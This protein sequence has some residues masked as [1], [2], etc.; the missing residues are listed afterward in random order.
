[1]SCQLNTANVQTHK[2]LSLEPNTE[3]CL[4]Y[5]SELHYIGTTRYADYIP[6]S[7][8]E[9]VVYQSTPDGN[10]IYNAVSLNFYGNET[11]ATT[12]KLS[13]VVHMVDDII[14]FSKYIQAATQTQKD[15]ST[16]EEV[17][18]Y[19]MIEMIDTVKHPYQD[20]YEETDVTFQTVLM[21]TTG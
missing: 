16:A 17:E 13:S 20:V 8:G 19:C 5:G 4:G 10:C 14:P 18:R 11:M 2:R 7:I 9:K 21:F 1:M 15:I 6:L 3:T 12:L